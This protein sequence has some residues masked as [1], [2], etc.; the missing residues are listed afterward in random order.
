MITVG[1]RLRRLQRLQSYPTVVARTDHPCVL[2]K[3][4]IGK[5]ETHHSGGGYW[6]RAHTRCVEREA[7]EVE[8]LITGGQP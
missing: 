1:D 6:Q 5:S 7:Q 3:G 8:R 4:W 2:C